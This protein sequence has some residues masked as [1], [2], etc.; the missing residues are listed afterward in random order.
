ME[1]RVVL[2]YTAKKI[3]DNSEY[4]ILYLTEKDGSRKISMLTSVESFNILAFVLNNEDAPSPVT[5]AFIYHCL[6]ALQAEIQKI[7]IYDV[8]DAFLAKILI[9]DNRTGTIYELE[10]NV[11]DGITVSCVC[12]CPI[13]VNEEVFQKYDDSRK[14]LDFDQMLKNFDTGNATK[15]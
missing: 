5:H 1:I 7:L 11:I 6:Q 8:T 9:K 14:I 10:I 3:R 12:G 15:H 13:Y 2:D 4:M